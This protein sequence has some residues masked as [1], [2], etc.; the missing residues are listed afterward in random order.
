[1]KRVIAILDLSQ[2]RAADGT[3][4]SEAAAER[5]MGAALDSIL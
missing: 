3:R 5:E 4:E 1:M 2:R